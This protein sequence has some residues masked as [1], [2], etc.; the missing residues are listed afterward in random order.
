[1]KMANTQTTWDGALGQR[2]LAPDGR[3][4]ELFPLE[5]TGEALASWKQLDAAHPSPHITASWPWV[6]AWL[7][8]FGDTVSPQIVLWRDGEEVIGCCLV[9]KSKNRSIGR[10][11]LTTYHLGTTGEIEPGGVWAEYVRPWVRREHEAAAFLE[12]VLAAVIHRPCHRIDVDGV[13]KDL[14]D[15]IGFKSDEI[16][17]RESP[18]FDF[19][20]LPN[21]K[22]ADFDYAAAILE[23]LG[24]SSR[25]NVKRRLKKYDQL[26]TT[27]TDSAD[28]EI[29]EELIALHQQRWVAAGDAGAFARPEFKQFI[30]DFIRLAAGQDRYMLTRVSDAHGTVGCQLLLRQE[31]RVFDFLSGFSQND[32]R[33]SPGLVC[34]FTNMVE[35]ASRGLDGYEFLVGD[36]RVK[37]DLSNTS[38][39]ICWAK[40]MK[41]TR[42]TRVLA[43]ARRLLKAVKRKGATA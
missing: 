29:L 37:R 18:L 10:I 23:Q 17:R 3:T 8:A 20:K 6:R 2:F 14:F 4:L 41:I 21:H 42:R 34:H 35:A 32:N 26:Q 19:H 36:A 1:M 33:P 30:R 13:D 38:R 16:E 25:K 12:Q 28:E 27:W 43:A 40:R 31:G 9:V 24:K 22:A 39:T 11:P 5:Q 7:D 15:A